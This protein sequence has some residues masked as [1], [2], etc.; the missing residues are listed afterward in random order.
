MQDRI[1]AISSTCSAMCGSQSET[2]R[3]LWPY[4]LKVRFDGSMP[5]LFVPNPVTPSVSGWNDGGTGWPAYFINSGLGS[6]RSTWLGPPSIKH[7]MMDLAR[8][9]T[10]GGLGSSG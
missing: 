1:T 6:N 10:R 4:C 2:H 3:P 8:G 5:F 7:Q 9:G